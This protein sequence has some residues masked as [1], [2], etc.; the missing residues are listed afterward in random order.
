AETV[1]A[2]LETYEIAGAVARVRE[3]LDL[4]T[5]W[6]VRTSRN[7]FWAEDTDAYQ[8]LYTALEV[9]LR[10]MAPLAP[11]VTEEIWR[12]LTGGRSVHLTDWPVPGDAD[13]ASAAALVA[14]DDLV[15]AMDAVRE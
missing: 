15:T 4:L 5:N 14:D 1:R 10:V 6:Y 7:R 11:M 9:L 2:D 13:D 8:T 3:H 12:G